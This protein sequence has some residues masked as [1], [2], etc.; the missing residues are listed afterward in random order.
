[1]LRIAF[2]P[3]AL[4]LLQANDLRIA[5][6]VAADPEGTAPLIEAYSATFT[7]SLYTPYPLNQVR[8]LPCILQS[9]FSALYRTA[10]RRMSLPAAMS[11]CASR[12]P[13]GRPAGP[14]AIPSTSRSRPPY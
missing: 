8:L 11:C 10:D 13:S 7:Q 12:P 2:L 3:R 1:M 4:C 9:T 14:V 6:A 5:Q